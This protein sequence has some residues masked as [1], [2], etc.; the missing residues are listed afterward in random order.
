M[1]QDNLSAKLYLE[2]TFAMEIQQNTIILVSE[3]LRLYTLLTVTIVI[4]ALLST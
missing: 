3:M 2:S 4:Y 1:Y